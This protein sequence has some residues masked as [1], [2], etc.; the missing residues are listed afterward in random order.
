MNAHHHVLIIEDDP[1]YRTLY[2]SKLRELGS[3]IRIRS[4]EN[5]YAALVALSERTP[6]LIILDLRMPKFDGV[7]LLDIVKSKPE[8]EALP[9]LVISSAPGDFARIRS[10]YRNVFIF[11]KPVRAD[12]FE[13][14]V[15]WGLRLGEAAGAPDASPGQPAH[16]RIDFEHMKLYIGPDRSIQHAVAEEFYKLA[17]DRISTLDRLAHSD[18]LRGVLDFCHAMEG[19][20]EAIGAHE[21][22]G[23]VESLRTAARASDCEAVRGHAQD[24]AEALRRFCVDLAH[25]FALD[26][27]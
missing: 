4:S 9:V 27:Q 2:A 1:F 22:L 7:A 6:D 21:V 5:G 19:G 23:T 26:A 3:D 18:D 10:A 12:L 20:A 25:E 16:S 17:A 24:F 15:R 11:A 14:A 13:R 8:Y